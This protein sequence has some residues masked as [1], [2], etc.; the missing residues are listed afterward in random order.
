[1]L[2][3]YG[4]LR[5]VFEIF[6]SYRTPIDMITTSEVSVSVTIDQT[7]HLDEII[8]DL[9]HYAN[10]EVH[11]DQSIVCVVGDL[12][13]EKEGVARQVFNALDDV[14]VRMISYGSS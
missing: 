4:F 6:E 8:K 14:R 1:M 11:S 13:A 12:I 9:K 3:A 10:V 5:K 2:L 7:D